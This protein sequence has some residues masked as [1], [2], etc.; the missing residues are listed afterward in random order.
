MLNHGERN[1]RIET[2]TEQLIKKTIWIGKEI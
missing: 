1:R 2:E